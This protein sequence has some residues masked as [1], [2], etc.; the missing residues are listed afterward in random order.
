MTYMDTTK[1][2]LQTLVQMQKLTQ[3]DYEAVTGEKFSA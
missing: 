1:E 2:Q 3:D